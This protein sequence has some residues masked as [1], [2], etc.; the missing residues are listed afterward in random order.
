MHRV[1]P[2]LIVLALAA[3]D[4]EPAPAA[5]APAA[6]AAPA[7]PAVVAEG[8]GS[9]A[10]ITG[11]VLE[12]M[13]AASYTYLRL[14]TPLGEV[15]AAVPEATVAVGQTVTLQSPMPMKNFSSRTLQRTFD[16]ILFATLAGEAGATP[17]AA[18]VA[19]A[20]SAPQ[21][22]VAVS[23]AEGADARTVAEVWAQKAALKDKKVVIHAQV[24]KATNGVMGK[25]WLHLRDGTGAEATKDHDLTVT[26][27]STAE[28]G[29]VVTVSGVVHTDKDFG[30]GYAY[31]VIVEDATVEK[32][33]ATP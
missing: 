22:A 5:S 10:A 7:S 33:A 27:A 16:T 24:V 19:A 6:P 26:S 20:P 14:E 3:C 12:T 21:A 23:K 28:V 2:L 32:D 13:N 30:A 15:W 31:G 18:P 11:K 4:K 1:S 17:A 25:N 29:D 9:Q 8:A